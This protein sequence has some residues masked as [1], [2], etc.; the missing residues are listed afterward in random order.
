MKEED[1]NSFSLKLEDMEN[2][3]YEDGEFAERSVY[4]VRGLDQVVGLEGGG[5]G[6]EF[7]DLNSL[8]NHIPLVNCI[9]SY[10]V[11]SFAKGK[12]LF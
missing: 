11:R 12:I 7:K 4:Q 3:L 1:R 10:I 9:F 6:E 5:G 2:W 8:R